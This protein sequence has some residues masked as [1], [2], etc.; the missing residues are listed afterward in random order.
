MISDRIAGIG[1]IVIGCSIYMGGL[2]ELFSDELVFTGHGKHPWFRGFLV[3]VL[4][5]YASI[6]AAFF[7]FCSS[8]DV[9]TTSPPQEPHAL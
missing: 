3:L 4:G 7:A 1:M 8:P 9:A 5:K 2:V 6:G